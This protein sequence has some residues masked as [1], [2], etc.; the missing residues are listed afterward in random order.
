[1]WIVLGKISNSDEV[2]FHYT[3]EA[4]QEFQVFLHSWFAYIFVIPAHLCFRQF[5]T[6]VWAEISSSYS[7]CVPG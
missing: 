3:K 7:G 1:M 2:F 5:S 4:E 6:S